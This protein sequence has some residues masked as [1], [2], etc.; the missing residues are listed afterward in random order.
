MELNQ[1][2]SAL[3]Q[4]RTQ[5]HVWHHQVQ[6]VGSFSQHKALEKYYEEIVPLVDGFVESVQGRLGII[7]SYTT[8][9]LVDWTEGAPHD[10]F[11]SLCKFIEEGRKSLPQ[12]SWIQNQIDEIVELL[13]EVKY[14]LTLK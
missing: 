2:V 12:E 6:G 11:M 13:Y 14:L 1:F 3:W 9:P 7:T 8:S 10:Y 5:S 4:S